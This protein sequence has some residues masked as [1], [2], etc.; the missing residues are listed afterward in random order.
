MIIPSVVR[1]LLIVASVASAQAQA[2]REYPLNAH[3]VVELDVSDDVTTIVFPEAITA[4]AGAGMLIDTGRAATE[5]EER[6]DL[7]FQVSH[8]PAS[9]FILVRS[10][11][12]DAVGRLTAIYKREAYVFE[13]RSVPTGS[14]ASAILREVSVPSAR[15]VELPPAAVKFTPKIGF[16]LLDRARAYPVLVD[17]LPRAV[18][19]VSLRTHDRTVEFAG[20]RIHVQE[21]YRFA[22]EDALVFLLRL[23]NVSD[24]ALDLAPET[25]AV[26]IGAERYG[27]SIANGPEVL[28][29][30]ESANAEFAIVGMPDGL[31]NDLS[32]DNAFT[33]LVQFGPKPSAIEE[34][35][36]TAKEG[37]AGE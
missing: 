14:I 2:I 36:P 9:N 23:T 6:A 1:L 8:A 25:F 35:V 29:P 5:V 19:G 16:S 3:A 30:G 34:P 18:D 15:P 32:A 12:P 33:V 31:R 17:A 22:R 7:R 4:I 27:Q 13:L 10:L 26:R 24:N 37:E 28:A 20:L 21:V 11:R